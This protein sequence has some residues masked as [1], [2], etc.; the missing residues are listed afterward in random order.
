MAVAGFFCLFVCL[1]LFYLIML[2]SADY[3]QAVSLF[4]TP[5]K[6]R[7]NLPSGVL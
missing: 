3:F 5:E 2:N 1:F 4:G 6:Y 7:D